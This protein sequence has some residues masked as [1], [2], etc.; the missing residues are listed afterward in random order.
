MEFI[1]PLMGSIVDAGFAW[2]KT[3]DSFGLP[4]FGIFHVELRDGAPGIS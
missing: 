2:K 3:A 4:A 1:G